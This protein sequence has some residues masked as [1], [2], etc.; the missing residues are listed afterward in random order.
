MYI[1]SK[2]KQ[3]KNGDPMKRGPVLVLCLFGEFVKKI[4]GSSSF[5]LRRPYAGDGTLKL[6]N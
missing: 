5:V 3:S 4:G 1:R 6:K 2:G